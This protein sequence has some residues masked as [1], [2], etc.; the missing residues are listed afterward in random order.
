MTWNDVSL[1][2]FGPW[3]YLQLQT[4]RQ[5]DLPLIRHSMQIPRD[6]GLHLLEAAVTSL[7]CTNDTVSIGGSRHCWIAKV[8]NF[9]I[10]SIY[11]AVDGK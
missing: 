7:L 1:G 8:D 11:D 5:K 2:R 9:A 3:I 10:T 4:E 6:S